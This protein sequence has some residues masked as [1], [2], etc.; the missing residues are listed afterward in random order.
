MT[1]ALHLFQ[2]L[3]ADFI[4]AYQL[5]RGLLSCGKIMKVLEK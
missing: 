5:K 3:Q 1:E 2:V 4:Q